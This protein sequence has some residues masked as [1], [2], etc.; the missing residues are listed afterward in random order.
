MRGEPASHYFRTSGISALAEDNGGLCTF[1]LGE[2]LAV[3]Q[4][5]NGPLLD[6]EDLAPSTDANREL[7][8]DFM[9]SLPHDH[10]ERPAKRAIVERSLGSS[11]FVERLAPHIRRHTAGFLAARQSGRALPLEDFALSLVA[12]VDSRLPG[13]LDFTCRPLDDYLRSA[14]YGAVVRGF[15]DLAS[16][17]ISNDNPGVM[18]ELDVIVPFVRDVLHANLPSLTAT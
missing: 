12:Y 16:D 8:G 3:Y 15:F 14:R 13:V 1:W 4:I 5:T 11:R 2:R 10:P 18:R 7:F 9:G 6:E 17:V